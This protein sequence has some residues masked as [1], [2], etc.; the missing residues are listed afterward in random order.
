ME[1]GLHSYVREW[2][3]Q[4]GNPIRRRMKAPNSICPASAIMWSATDRKPPP[5]LADLCEHYE[6]TIP[7][8]DLVNL[9][10]AIPS[11]RPIE[12]WPEGVG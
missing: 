10:A 8:V 4:T 2:M 9:A 11:L 12:H 1:I 6:G 7:S 3:Q 5:D